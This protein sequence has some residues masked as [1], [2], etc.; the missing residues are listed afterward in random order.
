MIYG[1]V[2][3]N[4]CLLDHHSG[5]STNTCWWNTIPFQFK[6]YNQPN[7]LTIQDPNK[8]RTRGT[9]DCNTE[10][11]GG[12]LHTSWFPPLAGNSGTHANAACGHPSTPSIQ[13]LPCGRNETW[14]HNC[15]YNFVLTHWA[16]TAAPET[17]KIIIM[18]SCQT[19]DNPMTYNESFS[20]SCSSVRYD[21][22]LAHIVLLTTHLTNTHNQYTTNTYI[23]N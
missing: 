6:N 7:I 4:H 1:P 23:I 19:T 21:L 14:P 8:F 3:V 2:I 9:G 5:V 16:E 22:H 20:N 15:Y 11:L 13:C 18:F 10:L 12:T 17:L